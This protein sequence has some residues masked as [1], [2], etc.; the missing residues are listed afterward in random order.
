MKSVKQ[1]QSKIYKKFNVDYVD[2]IQRK[3][4]KFAAKKKFPESLNKSSISTAAP[5]PSIIQ[6]SDGRVK[7]DY[8]RFS[9]RVKKSSDFYCP[10][11][12]SFLP[13][14]F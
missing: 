13:G 10:A 12:S 9:G 6:L 8:P 3:L 5:F 7:D 14:E 4:A 1:T 11:S 2:N